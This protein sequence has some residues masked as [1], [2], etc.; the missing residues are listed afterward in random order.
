MTQLMIDAYNKNHLKFRNGDLSHTAWGE[1]CA[2]MLFT[3]MTDVR[4]EKEAATKNGTYDE[5]YTAARRE[6]AN[7]CG[8]IFDDEG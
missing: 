6:I 3:I 1:F 8:F 5:G 2:A 4:G 7:K